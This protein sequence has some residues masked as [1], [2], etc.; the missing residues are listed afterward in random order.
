MWLGLAVASIIGL[1]LLA[2][3][4]VAVRLALRRN[5]GV[6][7]AIA[8]PACLIGYFFVDFA[9]GAATTVMQ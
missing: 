4:G 6:A 7:L 5:F 9:G 3:L 2:A 1:T 8:V